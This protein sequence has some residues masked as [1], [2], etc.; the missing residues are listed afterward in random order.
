[1]AGMDVLIEVT[2]PQPQSFALFEAAT[3]SPTAARRASASALSKIAG[4][5]IEVDT[6]RPPVPMLARK[7]RLSEALHR[8]LAAF[9]T[10]E[11]SPDIP[12]ETVVM[13]ARV[14]PA[15]LPAIRAR[16]D[17]KVWANSPIVLAQDSPRMH[18][19]VSAPARTSGSIDC[20]FS[21]V[22]TMAEVQN[23]LGVAVLWNLGHTGKDIVVG[24]LDVGIN[25]GAYPVIGGFA[26]PGKPQPGSA[27]VD[28]HGSMCA[29]DVLVAAPNAKFYDYPFLGIQDSGGALEMFEQ[30]LAQ[31]R[32]DGTPH[33]LNNSWGYTGVPDIAEASDHEIHDI[34]HPVHRKIEEIVAAG[35]PVFFAAGNCG[36]PCPSG[37]C[38]T[39][40]TGAGRSIHASNSLQEVITVAAVNIDRTRI[41]YS[42]QGPGMFEKQKPDIACYSHFFANFGVGR[43]GGTAER[44]DNGTSAASPLA[45]GAAA[46]LLQAFPGITPAQLKTMLTSTASGQ[47]QWNP[48]IGF[49]IIDL[50]AAHKKGATIS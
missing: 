21:R 36:G 44:Y 14:D 23:A 25:K 34:G 10:R 11:L 43:P 32:R 38:E 31:R 29:A 19:P 1:M 8:S 47:G 4:L 37:N 41:G 18:I 7:P 16:P 22:A 28:S 46:L 5:G 33:L 12:S 35:V 24:I 3:A 6:T 45:C 15:Q 27:R 20:T 42:S 49:G 26:V 17:V 13:R 30:A 2:Q 39:S 40:G 9:A 50:K 48:D